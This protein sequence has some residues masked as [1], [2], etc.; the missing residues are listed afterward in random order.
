MIDL[1]KYK[2]DRSAMNI[3]AEDALWASNIL[4]DDFIKNWIE[5]NPEN[6]FAREKY[7]PPFEKKTN[8]KVAVINFLKLKNSSP[9]TVLDISTGAGQFI[10]LCKELGHDVEGTETQQKLDTTATEIHT[11]YG[12]NVF[13]LT[14]QHGKEIKFEKSYDYITSLRTQFNDLGVL[15]T[16]NDWKNFKENM[17]DYLNPNGTLFLKTN[18]KIQKHDVGRKQQEMINAFGPPLLGWNSFTYCLK[19]V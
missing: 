18:L 1:K 4:N 2:A 7:Y 12:V 13:E 5:R 10:K 3:T 16:S 17:F 19:K 8:E 6:Y 14:I 9:K 15:W 11:H